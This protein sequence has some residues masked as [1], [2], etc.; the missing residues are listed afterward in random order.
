MLKPQTVLET[1]QALTRRRDDVI[2]TTGVGQHQ[3]WAMQYLVCDRP[4]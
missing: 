1:L 2:W 4:R 3:M